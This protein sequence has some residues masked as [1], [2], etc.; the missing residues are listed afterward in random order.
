MKKVIKLVGDVGGMNNSYKRVLDGVWLESELAG[1]TAEDEVE[2]IIH[3]FGG[4]VF[5][6]QYMYNLLKK[7]PSQ[8]VAHVYGSCM[9]MATILSMA[10]EKVYMC[11]NSMYMVHK[12]SS[13]TYGNA[14]DIENVLSLLNGIDSIAIET[15]SKRTKIT[16]ERLISEFMTGFDKWLTPTEALEYGFIDEIKDPIQ[17]V[18]E[19][20]NY[21][22]YDYDFGVFFQNAKNA[23]M[24]ERPL[25]LN[26][27][28]NKTNPIMETNVKE[29]T[30]NVVQKQ[31]DTQPSKNQ[32]ILTSL[33]N[34]IVNSNG[35]IAS[36]TLAVANA[37]AELA[38]LRTQLEA[39]Q[40]EASEKVVKAEKAEKEAMD[41]VNAKNIQLQKQEIKNQV[42]LAVSNMRIT[43]PLLDN[44][45]ADQLTTD[46]I[47]RHSINMS[48]DKTTIVDVISNQIVG[49]N[50]Q[51]SVIHFAIT[52]NFVIAT[53]TGFG[54]NANS[55][56]SA[57]S[58]SESYQKDIENKELQEVLNFDKKLQNERKYG[59]FS[60]S[61]CRAMHARFPNSEIAV[62]EQKRQMYNLKNK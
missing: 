18:I 11:E 56:L 16:K 49:D 61:W 48:D 29:A 42:G 39:F 59:K 32:E 57:T 31:V 44:A 26:N 14:N 35:I 62:P 46:Y 25:I 33:Q 20:E 54:N 60:E 7:C 22:D 15:Y 47:N 45:K 37:E 9:S 19:S 53:K 24:K 51:S 34:E 23:E 2:L 58:A 4:S 12:A 1:L 17:E 13:G 52:A 38:T 3:S 40:N 8:K 21:T 50:L 27:F 55:N 41:L 28:T 43:H 6:G 36:K 5:E 30:A 10:C